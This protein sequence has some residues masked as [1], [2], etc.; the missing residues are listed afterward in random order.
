MPAAAAGHFLNLGL[1]QSEETLT[2]RINLWNS[3]LFKHLA[4]IVQILG[5]DWSDF[6]G[7]AESI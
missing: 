6:Y 5:Q 7:V 4:K 2:V 1:M 3:Q